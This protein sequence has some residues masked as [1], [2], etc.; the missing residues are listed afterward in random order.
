MV[1]IAFNPD[2]LQQASTELLHFSNE[3]AIPVL[4][5]FDPTYRALEVLANSGIAWTSLSTAIAAYKKDNKGDFVTAIARTAFAVSLAAGFVFFYHYAIIVA[6]TED[7]IANIRHL[8]NGILFGESQEA[9][10]A[11]SKCLV[12]LLFL[13]TEVVTGPHLQLTALITCLLADLWEVGEAMDKNL[14]GR[15]LAYFT[16][17]SIRLNRNR[18]LPKALFSEWS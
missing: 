12:D 18:Q 10:K 14:Q 1:G 5:L 3:L 7:L 17:C 13:T 6:T 4:Y 2:R 11:L 15:G 16:R 8:S 9:F